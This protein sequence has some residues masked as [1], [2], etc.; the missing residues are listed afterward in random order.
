[1]TDSG[2]NALS[3]TGNTVALDT[4]QTVH[5]AL[6]VNGTT[7][8]VINSTEAHHVTFTV[9]GLEDETGTATFRDAHGRT[10]PQRCREMEPSRS[11]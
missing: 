1:M 10:H 5:P 8:G 3:A 11:I 7:D 2:G 4:D 6:S 9:S